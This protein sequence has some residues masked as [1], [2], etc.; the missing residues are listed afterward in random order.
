MSFHIIPFMLEFDVED[1]VIFMVLKSQQST[2]LPSQSDP[3][4]RF[5]LPEL[6]PKK[7]LEH[8]ILL[9][10]SVVNDA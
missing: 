3:I 8:N 5:L 9:V 2:K 10:H 6:A 1:H 4:Y 7:L